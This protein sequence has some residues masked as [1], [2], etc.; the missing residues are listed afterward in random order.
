MNTTYI[1]E[2]KKHSRKNRVKWVESIIQ[3]EWIKDEFIDSSE[4]NFFEDW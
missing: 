1:A 4:R 2:H 3:S